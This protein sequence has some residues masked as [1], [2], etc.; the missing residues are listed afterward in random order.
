MKNIQAQYTD[1]LE[2]R[3]SHS[4]FMVSVRRDFPQY[5]SPVTSFQDSVKILKGKR[6]LSEAPMG[7]YGHNPNN[8]NPPKPGIDH[9]NYYQ[10]YYG[11][12]YE[13][14]KVDEITDEVYEQVRKKVVDNILKDPH[15][16]MELKLANY[17]QVKE[18]DKD[19]EMKEVKKDNMV[20]K[21]NAMKVVKKD[22]KTNTQDTLTKKEKKKAKNGK[23]VEHM[24]MTPKGNLP[25]FE[26]PGKEKVKA[27]KESILDELT[28]PNVAHETFNAGSRVKKKDGSVVGEVVEWDGHTATVKTDDGK[29]IDIQGNV[30]TKRDVPEK[31][32]EKSEDGP[33]ENPLAKM[34]NLGM[35]EQ[36]WASNQVKEEVEES[37]EEKMKKLREKLTKAIK[38][39]LDEDSYVKG[40]G[41]GS[42]IATGDTPEAQSILQQKGFRKVSG[43]KIG[44]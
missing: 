3:M 34:P 38:K 28:M 1:L 23:G 22:E 35:V 14:S 41:A 4:N 10:A 7:V 9:V 24:T 6:I 19:L 33:Y 40:S 39:E 16:Y 25:A 43:L 20:D 11:I 21:A 8:E 42:T 17:K 31:S 27:L 36:K 18:M 44:E 37:R 13:L 15:A 29:H 26:T 2:G 5:I 12:Q 30:L 32:K